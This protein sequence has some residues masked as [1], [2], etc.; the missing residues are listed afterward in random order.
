MQGIIFIF[1]FQ[2]SDAAPTLLELHMAK[3]KS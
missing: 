1:S 2:Q 3:V